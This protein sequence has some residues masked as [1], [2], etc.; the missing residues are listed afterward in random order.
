M[1]YRPKGKYIDRQGFIFMNFIIGKATLN[2]TVMVYFIPLLLS[3]RND[4]NSLFLQ[5]AEIMVV[6]FENGK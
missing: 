1:V 2:H 6:L 4:L 3:F 5:I